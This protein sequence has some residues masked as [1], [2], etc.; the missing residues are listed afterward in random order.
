MTGGPG[1]KMAHCYKLRL[2]VFKLLQSQTCH[3]Q[4]VTKSDLSYSNY[5][6]VRLVILKNCY[7]VRLVVFKEHSVETA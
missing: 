4:I 5:Y 3:V 1:I 7:K 2:V 6:K